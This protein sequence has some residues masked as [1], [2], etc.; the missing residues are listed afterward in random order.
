[1]VA[2]VDRVYNPRIF[3]M[4]ATTKDG[5][6]DKIVYEGFASIITELHIRRGSSRM[7]RIIIWILT[8]EKLAEPVLRLPLEKLGLKT[9]DMLSVA[10]D[11][12]ERSVDAYSFSESLHELSDGRVSRV[13]EGG[14]HANSGA[15]DDESDGQDWMV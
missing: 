13:L 8:T 3:T 14:S 5:K 9:P 4:V 12:L 10:T 11:M 15:Q 2:Q 7:L 6:D 1:M